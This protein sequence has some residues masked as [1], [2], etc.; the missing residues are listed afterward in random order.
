MKSNNNN[1]INSKTDNSFLDNDFYKDKTIFCGYASVF[2]VVDNQGDVVL[3]EAVEYLNNSNTDIPILWQ[4]D[5]KKPIGRLITAYTDDVGLFVYG[6]IDNNLIYGKEAKNAILSNV[7]NSMSIGYKLVKYYQKNNVDEKILNYDRDKYSYV[8]YLQDI[9]ILEIS[10]V[11][12][13]ANN[14]T[15]IKILNN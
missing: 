12:L 6:Y 9:K 4:H 14:L 15:C 13:P 5:V 1:E 11:S 10:I 7:V 3:K 2:N 8:N